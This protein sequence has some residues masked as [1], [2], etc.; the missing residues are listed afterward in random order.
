[1]IDL[2]S[3]PHHILARERAVVPRPRRARA[4]KRSAL[5]KAPSKHGAVPFSAVWRGSVCGG[6]RACVEVLLLVGLK[7][8]CL[9]CKVPCERQ[10]L[11]LQNK[12]PTPAPRPLLRAGRHLP[13]WCGIVRPPAMPRARNFSRRLACCPAHLAIA[14]ACCLASTYSVS[15]SLDLRKKGEVHAG[16]IR[17]TADVSSC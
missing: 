5:M 10:R 7:V 14:S 17:V 9:R 15:L 8:T 4:R 16:D 1:M 6:S 2:R 12:V 11:R 13:R 3:R